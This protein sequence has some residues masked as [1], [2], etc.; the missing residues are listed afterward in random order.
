MNRDGERLLYLGLGPIAAVL[1][2]V[3]LTPLRGF[4]VASNCA[5]VFLALTFAVGELGGRAAALATALVSAL[6]L[7]FFL[8]QPYQRLMI[9]RKD[10]LIAFLGLAGCGLL[11]AAL[12]S[13]RRQ[14]L[15][16]GRQLGVLQLL[17]EQIADSTPVGERLP[18]LLD[19]A[20]HAF[21]VS[22]LALRGLD[23]RVLAASGARD[24]CRRDPAAGCR[25]E[26]IATVGRLLNWRRGAALPADGLRVEL[27]RAGRPAGFLDVWGDGRAAGP[28]ARRALTATAHTLAALLAP[29]A[30]AEARPRQEPAWVLAGPH[31]TKE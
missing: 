14:R 28:E 25:P 12:G 3:A 19:A 16:T 29:P 6:S 15:E 5:F 22:A 11:A 4:T 20:R 2:G 18:H 21:P 13:P 17:L 23:Q 7:D 8:T 26:A 1:L 24:L 9:H 31:A 27:V 10:D 30:Q